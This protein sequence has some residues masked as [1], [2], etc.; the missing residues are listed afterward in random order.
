MYPAEN[1]E[2]S[3]SPKP[4]D[5]DA[6]DTAPEYKR[7]EPPRAVQQFAVVDMIREEVEEKKEKKEEKKRLC[8]VCTV[9]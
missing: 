6:K 9:M 7:E 8:G 3:K 4:K 1:R 2:R 5:G